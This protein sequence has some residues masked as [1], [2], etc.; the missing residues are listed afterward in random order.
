L[1]D[2]GESAQVDLCGASATHAFRALTDD[3]AGGLMLAIFTPAL[4]APL[5]PVDIA[6]IDVF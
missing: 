1:H 5:K 4:S 3:R 6:G 2:N